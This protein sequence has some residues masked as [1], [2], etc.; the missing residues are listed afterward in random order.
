VVAS[1]NVSV[2]FDICKENMVSR[3]GAE[4][5][6]LS[7]IVPGPS[8]MNCILTILKARRVFVNVKQ[9]LIT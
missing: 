5:D 8:F 1:W 4:K 6:S 3:G 9:L 2:S 7:R